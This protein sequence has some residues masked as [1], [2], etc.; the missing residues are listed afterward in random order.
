MGLDSKGDV[1][2]STILLRLLLARGCEV[3][4]FGWI[5]HF[6]VNLCLA[7]TYNFGILAGKDEH[8]SPVRPS[9]DFANGDIYICMYVCICIYIYVYICIKKGG[10]IYMYIIMSN[11]HCCVAETSTPL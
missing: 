8:S 5:Q 10:Y 1:A 6:P 4:F 7:A 3:S 9:G 2:P 11:L